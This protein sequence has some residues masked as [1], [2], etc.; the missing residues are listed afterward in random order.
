VSNNNKNRQQ[1]NK[2]RGK[3]QASETKITSKE[4]EEKKKNK[5]YSSAAIP[6]G[7]MQLLGLV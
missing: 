7:S 4:T 6:K 5:L 3:K 1:T 2:I